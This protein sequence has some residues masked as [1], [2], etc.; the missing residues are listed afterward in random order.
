MEEE[1]YGTME[2]GRKNS[3]LARMEKLLEGAD[4]GKII[5]A[6][7]QTVIVGKPNVGDPLSETGCLGGSIVRLWTD[8]PP[9]T[10]REYSL[11]EYLN[12]YA[13]SH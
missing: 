5:R 10:T 6:G 8:I 12:I 11:R 3:V 4:R 9:G 2:P 1:T 13:D 7:L